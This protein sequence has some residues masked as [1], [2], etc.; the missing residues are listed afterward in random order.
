MDDEAISLGR[1]AADRL[2]PAGLRAFTRGDMPAA[3]NLLQRAAGT[4]PDDEPTRPR[5]LA[6]AGE[7]RM[8]TGAFR[9]A[10][11]LYDEAET[12]ALGAGDQVAA[13]IAELGR[14]RLRYL[15]GDGVTDAQARELVDRLTPIFEAAGDHRAL[16]GCGRLL[17]NVE[18][19][20]SQ[21]NA[22]GRA[23]EQMID[24]ARM[25]GDQLLERRGLPALAGVAMYGPTPVPAAIDRCHEVLEQAGDDLATRA[26]IERFVAHLM[27]FDGRFDEA[28][29]MC[30]ATRDRLSELGWHFDAALVSLS[31]GPIEILAG[32]PDDAARELQAAYDTLKGMGEQNF[33]TTVGAY[34]AE[35][36]R[37]Q[38]RLDDAL[39]LA[40]EAAAGAAEDDVP[41]QVA[42]RST[43]AKGLLE[44]ASAEEATRL[45]AEAVE[46]AN[47]T[48][49]LAMQGDALLDEAEVLGRHGTTANARASAEAALRALPLQA[50]PGGRATRP[51]RPG[52]AHGLAILRCHGA[53]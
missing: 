31:R 18:L 26:Y 46:L 39:G 40:A 8:E 13:G 45:A 22:A 3:A 49:D 28:R 29:D 30:A 20:H 17:F 52:R 37:R 5:L 53:G 34:L 14:L 1:R 7:A 48:D 19:T 47:G 23:A 24:Q 16:A 51:R 50:A 38:G 6:R 15:T 36:V 41:T 21:W 35:A 32:R 2:A 27:A 44:P 43:R 25:A 33:I 11:R 42:W 10:I 4:L 12:I 9:E